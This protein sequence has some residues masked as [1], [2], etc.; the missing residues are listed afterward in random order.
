[1]IDKAKGGSLSPI[2]EF[3]WAGAAGAYV[4]IDPDNQIALFYI[5]QMLNSYEHYVHPRI[6]NIVYRGFSI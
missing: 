4:M 1:M 3:G 6:R 5:Q 2:G